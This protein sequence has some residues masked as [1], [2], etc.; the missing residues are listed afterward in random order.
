MH[1]FHSAVIIVGTT[2]L[3]LLQRTTVRLSRRICITRSLYTGTRICLAPLVLRTDYSAF[4]LALAHIALL[5]VL[6]LVRSRR[7]SGSLLL[8]RRS[9]SYSSTGYEILHRNST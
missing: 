3:V 8:Y 5:L 1:V 6:A 9:E 4:V 7:Q 2:A